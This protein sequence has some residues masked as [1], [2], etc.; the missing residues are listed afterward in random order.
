MFCLPSFLVL[1]DRRLPYLVMKDGCSHIN[2][3][4]IHLSKCVNFFFNSLYSVAVTRLLTG[5]VSYNCSQSHTPRCTESYMSVTVFLK[6][7]P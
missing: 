3:L 7:S 4:W 6:P 2:G 1:L 5:H